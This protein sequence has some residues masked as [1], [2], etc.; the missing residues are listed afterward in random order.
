MHLIYCTQPALLRYLKMD[1]I[2]G[3]FCSGLWCVFLL[4]FGRFTTAQRANLQ[5]QSGSGGI[6]LRGLPELFMETLLIAIQIAD[7]HITQTQIP[8]HLILCLPATVA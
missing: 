1:H 8:S 3:L 2:T 5:Q 6:R 4:L 7:P